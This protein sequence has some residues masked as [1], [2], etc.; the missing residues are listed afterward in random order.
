[1]DTLYSSNDL[2]EK[3][4]ISVSTVRKYEQDYNLEIMRNESNNRVYTEK[5]LEIFKKI[6]EL[7][8]EG[9]NIHLIRKILANEGI[10]ETAPE[11]LDTI[12]LHTESIEA[13]KADVISQIADI[14]SEK[15]RVLKEE[16]EKQLDEK[17]QHQE[18][19]IREQ[20]QAE[21]KKLMEYI[22]AT[23]ENEK[24]KGFWSRIFGK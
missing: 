21:N 14:V 2:A 16:F 10:V 8:N 6:I 19:R 3:L 20:I 22:A 4:G 13:F 7:K 5:D 18:Q 11:V 24:K 9:A 1:M 12:P 23:K 17:L 15:E